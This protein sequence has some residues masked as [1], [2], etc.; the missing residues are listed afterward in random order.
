MPSVCCQRLWR[1]QSPPLS[2]RS[3]SPTTS[4]SI[5][6]PPSCSWCSRPASRGF[7]GGASISCD[8][9]DDDRT[10]RAAERLAPSCPTC[11]S[12]S[13]ASKTR[14]SP[15][16]SLMD[17]MGILPAARQMAGVDRWRR[18]PPRSAHRS[19]ERCRWPQRAQPFSAGVI[20]STRRA[21]AVS[22]AGRR[23]S[24]WQLVAS[25]RASPAGR[26][27]A[28]I[29]TA[30]ATAARTGCGVGSAPRDDWRGPSTSS[31]HPLR[32]FWRAIE[33][34]LPHRRGA[35]RSPR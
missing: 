10:A 27:P 28:P 26:A 2:C 16:R 25:R 5:H 11:M 31:T 33:H 23:S 20:G 14:A 12:C 19:R 29:A 6:S 1:C 7:S 3:R 17:V 18:M 9:G 34:R 15:A 32:R 35:S 4:T 22:K 21:S 8:D 30:S 24:T 13:T